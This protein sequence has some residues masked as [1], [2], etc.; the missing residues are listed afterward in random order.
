MDLAVLAVGII[1]GFIVCYMTV[2]PGSKK[3]K[4][5]GEK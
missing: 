3:N 5:D 1:M 2:G 4:K